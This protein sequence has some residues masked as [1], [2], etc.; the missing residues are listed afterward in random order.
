MS[1]SKDYK[2]L[3]DKVFTPRDRLDRIENIMVDGMPDINYC[4]EGGFEGWI[5]LKSPMEPKRTTTRLFGSNHKLSQEQKNWFMRQTTAKGTAFILIA[6]DKHWILI[7]GSQADDINDLTV[8]QL[9]LNAL[10][11]SALPIKETAWKQL[12]Q[13]LTIK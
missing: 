11:H 7:H 9:I 4:I 5:E 13:S 6:S 10:W 2:K 1:E 8:Q 12:R 3:R